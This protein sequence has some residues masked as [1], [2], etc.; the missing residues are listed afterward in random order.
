[1]RILIVEDEPKT[2]A[3]VHKGL[4]EHGYVVDVAHDGFDGLHL[5]SSAD[6]D[7][8]LLDVML[9][10]LDGWSVLQGVRKHRQTPVLFLTAMD[11]VDDRVKG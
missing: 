7:L 9:P 1:M 10:G 4:T 5:A 8:I 11:K 2:A 3:Y 6:Y